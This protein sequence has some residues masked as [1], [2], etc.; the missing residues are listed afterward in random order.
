MGLRVVD[1][2]RHVR[3]RLGVEDPLFASDSDTEA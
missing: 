3:P 1:G 2:M